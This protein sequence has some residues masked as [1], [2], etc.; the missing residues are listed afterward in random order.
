LVSQ[1]TAQQSKLTA[2]SAAE[3]N[4]V[5]AARV[6]ARVS[7]LDSEGAL[8]EQTLQYE[9]LDTDFRSLVEKYNDV[10]SE[11][12]RLEQKLERE[13]YRANSLEAQLNA[14]S[15]KKQA[16]ERS[17]QMSLSATVR[18]MMQMMQQKKQQLQALN[19]QFLAAQQETVKQQQQSAQTAAREQQLQ[20][21]LKQS[22]GVVEQLQRAVKGEEKDREKAL[23]ELVD[24]RLTVKRSQTE[25]SGV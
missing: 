6:A 12:G 11:V 14:V 1:L 20:A 15:A 22:S 17:V 2:Q 4:R 24:A 16:E 10:Y 8:R 21:Q 7:A 13:N 23:Q 5:N 18:E 3:L 19:A 9:L 25:V